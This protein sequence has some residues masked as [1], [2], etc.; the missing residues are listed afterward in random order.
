MAHRKKPHA[1]KKL[2]GINF[3]YNVPLNISIS[4]TKS[5]KEVLEELMKKEID[6]VRFG[7]KKTESDLWR[8]LINKVIGG[9]NLNSMNREV[10]TILCKYLGIIPSGRSKFLMEKMIEKCLGEDTKKDDDK[11]KV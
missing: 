8:E 6:K 9:Q 10:K 7:R 11:K 1:E 5:E 4:S 2:P 3:I